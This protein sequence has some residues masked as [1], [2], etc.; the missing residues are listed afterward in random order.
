MS[1]T[2]RSSLSSTL[3]CGAPEGDFLG[4]RT[5]EQL[6]NRGG[7]SEELLS[8]GRF[9]ECLLAS[10]KRRLLTAAGKAFGVTPSSVSRHLVEATAKQLKHLPGAHSSKSFRSSRPRPVPKLGPLEI[11]DKSAA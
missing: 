2:R 5:Y 3:D 6:K 1:V 11:T 4:L 10:T 8:D 7:F 9:G